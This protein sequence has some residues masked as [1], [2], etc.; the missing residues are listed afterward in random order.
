VALQSTPPSLLLN[1]P[2]LPKELE[3]RIVGRELVLHDTAPGIIVDFI[4][5]VVPQS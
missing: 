3:Y 2:P 4:P 5:N 1:L